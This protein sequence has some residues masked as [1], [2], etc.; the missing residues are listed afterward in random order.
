MFCKKCGLPLDADA[1]FCAGCGTASGDAAA[2]APVLPP[3]KK[4]IN[5]NVLIIV[6][7][8]VVLAGAILAGVILL[9]GGGK[10]P[11]GGIADLTGGY[12][13]DTTSAAPQSGFDSIE[14]AL[15]A[16]CRYVES[17]DF[18]INLSLFPDAYTSLLSAADIRDGVADAKEH[19]EQNLEYL[20]APFTVSYSI[21][22]N[23]FC[24]PEDAWNTYGLRDVLDINLVTESRFVEFDVTSRGPKGEGGTNGGWYFVK[25][26]GRWYLISDIF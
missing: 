21:T 16:W 1:Q 2:L 20:G 26:E 25:M 19:Y 24:S 3:A 9:S 17:G 10:S 22:N 7:A 23:E 5:K 8:V 6:A 4:G 14:A 13:V 12:A 15:D 11:E 18:D